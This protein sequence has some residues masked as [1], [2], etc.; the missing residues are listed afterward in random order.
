MAER[1]PAGETLNIDVSHVFRSTFPDVA[2]TADFRPEAWRPSVPWGLE[3]MRPQHRTVLHALAEAARSGRGVGITLLPDSVDAPEEHRSYRSI[4]Q[5]ALRIA[6]G[7]TD[8]GLRPGDRVLIVLPTSF[9]FITT[10]FGIGLAG[11]ISVPAY[12]PFGLN[13]DAGVDRLCHIAKH[14]EPCMC[15]TAKRVRPLLGKMQL[16]APTVRELLLPEQVIADEGPETQARPRS[17]DPAFIQYTSGSTGRQKGVL[18]AHRNLVANIQGIGDAADVRLSDVVVSWLPLYHDMGLIGTVLFS[19]YW[20]LPLALMSPTSFLAKPVRWLSTITRHRGT[21]SPAP[22][23]A[24]GLCVRKVRPEERKGLDLS[25]W[26]I[27]FNGA[28]PVSLRTVR[29]FVETYQPHG[30]RPETMAP[31]YGLAE[32]SLAATFPPLGHPV[33][34]ETVDRQALAC[35][36]ALPASGRGSMDLVSVGSPLPGHEVALVDEEGR[37]VAERRVGHIVVRG[38]SLM[39]GY[40]RDEAATAAV[41]RNEWLWTGDLGF[42]ADGQLYVSGRVK[43]LI[44]LRGRNFFAEDIERLAERVTGVRAGSAVA[45]AVHDEKQGTELAVLVC[46]TRLE[47]EDKRGAL[48]TEVAEAVGGFAGVHLGEVVV[49]DSGTLPKTSSGKK[50]RSR[51]RELYLSGDIFKRRGGKLSQAMVLAR[52]GASFLLVKARRLWSRRRAPE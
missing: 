21:L 29:E 39:R 31:V 26:R 38:P 23:F 16:W 4:F 10:F 35:G 18:L 17:D 24:Y 37:A 25:S 28:E 11:G 41:I 8:R 40:F 5:E 46:E 43:D 9:E 15:I 6:R 13:L 33:R 30:F 19:V 14:A 50:Q 32:T 49:V 12:P 34:W 22:N 3:E 48:A 51:C 44:I 2:A 36:H 20:R 47:G 52:S 27:A 7:L 1:P 45:F 42:L